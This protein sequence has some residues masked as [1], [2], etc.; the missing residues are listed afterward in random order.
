MK[1]VEIRELKKVKLDNPILIA[2]F[3]G[4]GYVGKLA[5]VHM[6][7]VFKAERL[8]EL[9]SKHFPH[10][11]LSDKDG[12]VRPLRMEFYY[13]V[14]RNPPCSLILLTGDSQLQDVEGQYI[15]ASEILRYAKDKGVRMVVTMGGYQHFPKN[16]PM[17]LG[18]STSP[19]LLKRLREAGAN[20]GGWGNP[21]V[22]LAGVLVGL[23]DFYG[24]VGVCL[25]GETPGYVVD[26]KAATEVLKVLGRF[27]GLQIP[28]KGIKRE[29]LP[30]VGEAISEIEAE[31]RRLERILRRIREKGVSYI[32]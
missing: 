13:C 30:E 11:V 17:V 5:V 3:P 21:I 29:I 12:L 31:I 4:L 1:D 24:M 18:A 19:R 10:H 14:T 20:V 15:A 9:Y 8:A 6:I 23:T 16:T 2:G 26:P 22:G 28:L 27:I 25:L 32:S 7:R